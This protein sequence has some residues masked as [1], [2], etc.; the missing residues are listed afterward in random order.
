MSQ[1]NILNKKT[2]LYSFDGEKISLSYYLWIAFR[3]KTTKVWRN[4]RDQQRNFYSRRPHRSFRITRRKDARRPIKMPGYISFTKSVFKVLK[5]N[6]KTFALLTLLVS[7]VSTVT[8]GLMSQDFFAAISGILNETSGDIFSGNW[9]EIGKATLL[10]LSTFTTGGLSTNPTNAQRVILFFIFLFVWL[11]V[12][13]LLRYILAGKQVRLRD[14]L[15]NCGGPIGATFVVLVIILIQAVPILV[16]LIIWT[17]AASTELAQNGVEHMILSGA[18]ILLISLS[19]FW[20]L[21]SLFGIVISALPGVYPL[22][23]LSLSGDLVTGRRLMI[24]KRLIWAIIVSMLILFIIIVP[25]IL[26]TNFLGSHFSIIGQ[27]PI[28]PVVLLPSS[29]FVLIFIYSYI[30]LLYR[31]ITKNDQ[32]I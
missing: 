17:T 13:W 19:T 9:G 23:A 18:G 20:V 24:L 25:V 22:R 6:W 28:V 14:A 32:S 31:E 10:L 5:Q 3:I 30:Y 29:V 15:Y 11:V 8:I 1:K 16:S 26:L 12:V 2:K 27:L 21:G 7:V 4:I